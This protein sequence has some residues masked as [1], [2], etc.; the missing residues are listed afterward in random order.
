MGQK[1]L[2]NIN[3]PACCAKHAKKATSTKEEIRNYFINNLT[4]ER[5][6]EYENTIVSF[7]MKKEKRPQMIFRKL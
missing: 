2:L 7:V 4:N 3:L 5:E 6:R 1:I